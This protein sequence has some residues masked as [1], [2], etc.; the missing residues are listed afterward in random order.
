MGTSSGGR[1]LAAALVVL[2]ALTAFGA[3]P[4]AGLSGDLTFDGE[5]GT[6]EGTSASAGATVIAEAAHDGA[7]GLAVAATAAPGFVRWNPDRIPQG[8]THASARLWLRVLERGAGESV[9]LFTVQNARRTENFD[10]FV[11][12]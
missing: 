10:L 11:N 9:D 3:A 7:G 6:L 12:G 1:V 8:R 2:S 4:A 5:S